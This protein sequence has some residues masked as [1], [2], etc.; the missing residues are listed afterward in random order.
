LRGEIIQA[1]VDCGADIHATWF[2]GRTALH[3]AVQV[4]TGERRGC[5]HEGIR[6]LVQAG[7]DVDVPDER[8]D[9]PLHYAFGEEGLD[10]DAVQELI[11]LGADP[12]RK[13]HRGYTAFV[14]AHGWP[15]GEDRAALKIL[16]LSVPR[17]PGY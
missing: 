17:G 5:L 8:G 3:E 12:N 13:D 9:T 10:L 2:Q 6:V 11:R 7:L 4:H 14:L 1:L 16:S 15:G